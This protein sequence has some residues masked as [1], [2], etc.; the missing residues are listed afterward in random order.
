MHDVSEEGRSY[1]RGGWRGSKERERETRGRKGGREGG[2]EGGRKREREGASE[3]EIDTC[4]S[5]TRFVHEAGSSRSLTNTT[6]APT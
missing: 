2:R 6:H 3:R 1:L 4:D 5:C